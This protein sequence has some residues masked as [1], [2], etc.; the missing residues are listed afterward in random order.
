MTEWHIKAY[1]FEL[2]KT[3]SK[4]LKAEVRQRQLEF[5]VDMYYREF[6]KPAFVSVHELGDLTL[7]D[8]I[9]LEARKGT[10]PEHVFIWKELPG[11]AVVD[12]ALRAGGV[13]V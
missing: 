4:R 9:P 3:R 1:A 7:P 2:P 11:E 8:D 5:F 12:K 6:G 10:T 13:E